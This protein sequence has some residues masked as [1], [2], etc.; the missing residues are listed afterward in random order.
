[1]NS[2]V[3]RLVF[4][5]GGPY[6]FSPELYTAQGKLA[7]SN[8]VFASD[9]T[10]FFTRDIPTMTILKTNHITNNEDCI[11]YQQPKQISRNQTVDA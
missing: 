8:D 1:M 4:I 5:I 6:G 2:G 9:G 11:C 10:T 3:K 7:L